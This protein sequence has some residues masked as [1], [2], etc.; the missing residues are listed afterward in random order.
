MPKKKVTFDAEG[1]LAKVKAHRKAAK[2]RITW[3]KSKLVKHRAEMVKMRKEGASFADIQLW[4]LK[5]CGIASDES[6]VRRYM[7]KLPE[8]D[9]A[10]EA[11][12]AKL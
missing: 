11:E 6:T 3:G 5:A 7:Q 8:L 4:L 10:K 12:H 2:R 1:A 9:P